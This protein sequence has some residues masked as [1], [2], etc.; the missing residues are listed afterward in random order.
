MSLIAPQLRPDRQP[1]TVKLDVRLLTLLKHYAEFIASSPDYIVN[2][3][4]LVAFG[5]DPQ[6]VEWL[7]DHH[8]EDGDRLGELAAEQPRAEPAGR[9]RGRPAAWTK[10][11]ASGS[12][13]G[14]SAVDRK[15]AR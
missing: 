11:A 10:A 4:L 8:P 6:F 7:A 5:H 2:Q 9:L 13:T 15:D 1:V 3:A 12:A 14:V